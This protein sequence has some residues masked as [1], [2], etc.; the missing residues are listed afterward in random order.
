MS[1]F[2][3]I[4]DARFRFLVEDFGFLPSDSDRE[5]VHYSNETCV[6]G[7]DLEHGI[8]NAWIGPRWPT[9]SAHIAR[10]LSVL[11]VANCRGFKDGSGPNYR[12]LDTRMIEDIDLFAR[13][14]RDYCSDLLSGDF[15]RWPEIVT[16]VRALP[17]PPGLEKF[18]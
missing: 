1:E 14:L 13:L 8:P 16:C 9:D 6:V 11:L 5:R 12:N 18:R 4:V 3:G 7:I 10:A 17:M 15:A 2:P